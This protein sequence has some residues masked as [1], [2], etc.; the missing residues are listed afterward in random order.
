MVDKVE[1]VRTLVGR[2]SK[3]RSDSP[4]HDSRQ[5]CE[6]REEENVLTMRHTDGGIGFD[7][8]RG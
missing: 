1:V 4:H 5:G 6:S 2:A 3:H 7:C 8:R